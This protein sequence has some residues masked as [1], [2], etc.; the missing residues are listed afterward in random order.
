M[1]EDGEFTTED[2]DK[3]VTGVRIYED[4][5][6]WLLNL[7]LD[8]RRELDDASS[9]VYFKKLTVTPDDER[10]WFRTHPQWSKSNRY[11]KLEARI[12]I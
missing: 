7:N 3:Y 9:P 2:I 1:P 10:E 6:E 8:T 12:Y 11:A 4:H 5:F